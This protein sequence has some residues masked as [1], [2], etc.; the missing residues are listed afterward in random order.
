V[1]R[2]SQAGSPP[3]VSAFDELLARLRSVRR[4]DD[5]AFILDHGQGGSLWVHISD[6]A[7]LW[8][9]PDRDGKHPG[10]S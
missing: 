6:V 3:I 4:G 2:A 10:G 9:C 7:F 8:F 5:G 1:R